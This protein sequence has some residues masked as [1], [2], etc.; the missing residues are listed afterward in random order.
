MNIWQLFV[1]E[2]KLIFWKD[3]RRSLFLFGASVTYL[4][5]F[6]LLYGP[7]VVKQV[8]IVICDE[9]QS[10][11]SRSLIQTFAD[12]ERFKIVGYP[13]NQDAAEEYL[14]EKTAYG[15]V[16]IPA[17]FSQNVKSGMGSNVLVMINGANLLFTNTISTAAQE[18]VM[19]FSRTAGIN[20]METGGLLPTMALNRI[21]P[22]DFE[23]RVQNN[24]TLSYLEFFIIGLALAAFQQG[25]FLSTGASMSGEAFNREQIRKTPSFDFFLGKLLP[26][27]LCGMVAFVLTMYIAVH[28][29]HIPF[30]GDWGSLL[31]LAMVFSFAAINFSA[32]VGLLCSDEVL[33]TR[34]SLV[35]TVPAFIFSGH[36]WP[37]AAMDGF[38]QVLAYIFPLYYF[39][40]TVRDL[41][42]NG[43]SPVYFRNVGILLL[44]AV[45]FL[46]LSV[47]VYEFKRHQSKLGDARQA[48]LL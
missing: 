37:Q 1:S 24:P 19:D 45:L 22:L 27:L 44:M 3:P 6:G 38:S 14:H 48:A 26:Y 36:I 13:V 33:F 28:L 39:A 20:L 7:A 4:V 40:D 46:T 34:L 15:A 21:G 2:I 29:F 17:K 47:A 18:I 16:Y 9:D 11:F 42:L 25:L 30:R 12:S 43:Y 8:P 31:I 32:L 5:L 23:L 41:M 35:Y 10:M